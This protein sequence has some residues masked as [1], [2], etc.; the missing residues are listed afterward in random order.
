[1]SGVCFAIWVQ[2]PD[3]EGGHLPEVLSSIA[4]SER[5]AKIICDYKTRHGF[6]AR[7]SFEVMWTEETSLKFWEDQLCATQQ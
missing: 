4:D 6:I 3:G 5:L 7:Y 1:M 2:V